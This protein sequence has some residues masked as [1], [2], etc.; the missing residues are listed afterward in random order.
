VSTSYASSVIGTV[1]RPIDVSTVKI[2]VALSRRVTALSTLAFGWRKVF[3]MVSNRTTTR[4]STVSPCESRVNSRAPPSRGNPVSA[5]SS[6]MVP[7][8]VVSNSVALWSPHSC[9]HPSELVSFSEQ[10]LI[11]KSRS[12]PSAPRMS[13]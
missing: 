8:R 13:R 11:A 9:G 2:S 4:T 1:G 3:G 12:A 10:A 7:V 6:V 5:V